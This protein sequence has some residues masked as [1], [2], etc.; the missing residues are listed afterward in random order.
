MLLET[1]VLFGVAGA[2]CP[3]QVNYQGSLKMKFLIKVLI[4]TGHPTP[5]TALLI[6]EEEI[7][8]LNQIL[9]N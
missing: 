5:H 3:G 2:S 7:H 6:M 4:T 9:V 8:Y 1:S